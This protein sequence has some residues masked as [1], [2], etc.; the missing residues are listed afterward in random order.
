MNNPIKLVDPNGKEVFIVGDDAQTAFNELKGASKLTLT[1]NEKTG[2]IEA[3]GK[4]K[5][6]ND[7][8]LLEA[9]N[10]E[11]VKVN[12][13]ANKSN[14]FEDNGKKYKTEIGGAFMGNKLN[15]D[16][17]GNVVSVET[18]QFIST[19]RMKVCFEPE[20]IGKMVMH[21]ITESYMGGKISMLRKEA[22]TPA[23]APKGGGISTNAIF[24]DAH[25]LATPQPIN[26]PLY[27]LSN[28]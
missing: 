20:D 26:K 23:Y 28:P 1:R 6:K 17:N 21:E 11:K 16:E 12:V 9:I 14:V 24:R 10:S 18:K 2:K 4:A 8:L 22:A 15:F 3:T 7:K 19:D 5:N 13:T 25:S 27:L